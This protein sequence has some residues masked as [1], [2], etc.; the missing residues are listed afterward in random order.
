MNHLLPCARHVARRRDACC[1]DCGSAATHHV[2]DKAAGTQITICNG[3]AGR[4]LRQAAYYYCV[5]HRAVHDQLPIADPEPDVDCVV[6]GLPRKPGKA[7]PRTRRGP[8]AVATSCST[9]IIV[10]SGARGTRGKAAAG[11]ADLV[12]VPACHA[13]SCHGVRRVPHARTCART[14]AMQRSI[15]GDRAP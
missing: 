1:G 4:P 3:M 6:S 5:A 11:V 14:H 10:F 9:M 2:A 8:L 13:G 15:C 12:N 7:T